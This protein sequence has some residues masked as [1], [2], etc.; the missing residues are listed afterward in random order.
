[1]RN[2]TRAAELFAE[3]EASIF[4]RTDRLFAVLM[5]VQWVAGIAAALWLTPYTWSGE[6]SRFHVHVWAAVVLGG[7]LALGPIVLAVKMPG[8]LVTRHVIAVS[9]MLVS[10]LLIHLTGGRIET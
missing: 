7:A 1:M 2:D 3:H 6:A 9:Q 10:A 8:A 5:A 4:R